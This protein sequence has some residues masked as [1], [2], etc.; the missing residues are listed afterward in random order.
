V[1]DV[2]SST[3]G[4][5]DCVL[6]AGAT[7]VV[8]V[9]AGRNQLHERL[10][11]DPRVEVHERTNIRHVGPDDLGGPVSLVVADLSFISLRTVLGPVLALLRPEGRLVAL[12]KPQFE[13]QPV[14]ASRGRGVIVDPLV[15]RRVLGE[16][17]DA[18]MS[19]GA[20]MM[21]VMVSPITGA[22]G[23]VEF[24]VL[25]TRDGVSGVDNRALDEVVAEAVAVTGAAR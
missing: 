18:L 25:I 20:A 17:R 15:W 22:D 4:F 10:R 14:E 21:G 24:L 12:L 23:N 8:A 6:Q 16:V 7:T 3:G 13:A 5:T 1:I 19:H 2:G 11:A 9:D